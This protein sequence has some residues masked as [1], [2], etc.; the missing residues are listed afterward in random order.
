MSELHE[1]RRANLKAIIG[2]EKILAFA[3]RVGLSRNQ[4]VY[5]QQILR[6]KEPRDMGGDFARIFESVLSIDSGSLDKIEPDTDLL[7]NS[8]ARKVAKEADT[9]DIPQH[10]QQAVLYMLRTA[11]EKTTPD[12][13]A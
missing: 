3:R 10:M 6:Q 7:K 9:R 12:D 4:S 1:T 2:N 13:K 5:I 8:F 11:P